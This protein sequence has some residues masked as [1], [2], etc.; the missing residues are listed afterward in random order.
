MYIRI[1]V[2]LLSV[3]SDQRLKLENL[4]DPN[5]AEKEKEQTQSVPWYFSLDLLGI[6]GVTSASN[7]IPEKLI[8]SFQ[9]GM[10]LFFMRFGEICQASI[11]H[12]ETTTAMRGGGGERERGIFVVN[13]R[14]LLSR[15]TRISESYTQ[16][17]A[18]RPTSKFVD[19]S[20]KTTNL[21]YL[22]KQHLTKFMWFIVINVR[23]KCTNHS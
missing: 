6:W 19:I 15:R 22:S 18:T 21:M 16:L 2:L 3:T 11:I 10:Q 4:I 20:N 12:D 1:R 13:D 5:Y 14:W 7:K 8:P 17:Q 9:R 23:I